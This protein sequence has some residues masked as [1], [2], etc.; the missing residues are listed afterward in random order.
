MTVAAAFLTA[1]ALSL[2]LVPVFRRIALRAGLVAHPKNDRWHRRPTALLGGAAI[3]AALFGA[4]AATGALRQQPVLL[5][6]AGLIFALGLTDDLISLKPSTKLVAQ[7]ALASVFL[8]FGQ[9]LNWTSSITLD[10]V[11]TIVWIVGV[12]NAFN[13]LDNM[14]G[15]CAG[16]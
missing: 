1:F 13:L 4:L 9:R 12:T 14:D 8:G 16:I 6:C 3:A 5:V 7:I 11:L 2:I 10:S 15:L